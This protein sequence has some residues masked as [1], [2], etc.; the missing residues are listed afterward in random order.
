MSVIMC[1]APEYLSARGMPK[2]IGDLDKHDTIIYALQD[3]PVGD[4]LISR[5]GDHP[6]GVT[7][8]AVGDDS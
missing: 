6:E 1:A 3:F 7:G 4:R 8:G 5:V 2:K